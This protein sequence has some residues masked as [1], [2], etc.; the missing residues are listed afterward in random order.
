MTLSILSRRL[1][2]VAAAVVGAAI[3]SAP[4]ASAQG[5]KWWQSEMFTR[6]LGLTAEQSAKIPGNRLVKARPSFRASR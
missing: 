1:A 6:E 4:V 2:L 5:F 3:L